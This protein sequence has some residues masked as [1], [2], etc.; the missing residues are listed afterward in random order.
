MVDIFIPFEVIS[1]GER[2]RTP[3]YILK[4]KAEADFPEN[5]LCPTFLIFTGLTILSIQLII[6]YAEYNFKRFEQRYEE[7]PEGPSVG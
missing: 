3:N 6:Q 4:G 7:R 2:L 5:R 1:S